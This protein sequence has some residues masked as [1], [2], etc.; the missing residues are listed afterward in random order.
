MSEFACLVGPQLSMTNRFAFAKPALSA[1]MLTAI[2]ALGFERMTPV[3][4]AAIPHFLTNKVCGVI[5][6][7][8]INLAIQLY[9]FARRM[10]VWKRALVQARHLLSW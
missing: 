6:L 8:P 7:V 10:F 2:D 5:K 3:Q 1:P 4:S 9:R